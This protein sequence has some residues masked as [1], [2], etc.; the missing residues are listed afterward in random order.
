MRKEKLLIKDGEYLK[1]CHDPV[2]QSMFDHVTQRAEARGMMV[3]ENKTG[4]MCISAAQT[5][6]PGAVLYGK[7]GN[8]IESKEKMRILGFTLDTD[9]GCGSHVGKTILKIRR[10]SWAL[11]KLK[12]Y[13][14][15]PEE[16][17][18]VY[19]SYIRPIAEYVS[20]AWHSC[21][22]AEQA[23][24]LERQQT[25]ALRLIFGYG[26][27][28]RKLRQAANIELLSKRR[29]RACG[30]FAKKTQANPRFSSWFKEREFTRARRGSEK[31]RFH[32][33]TARTDR[34]RNSPLN[35]LTRRLNNN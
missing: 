12:R 1:T 23:A 8:V 20:A 11:Q 9:G 22:T 4:L 21:L 6:K 24:L 19:A 15:S 18:R 32:E 14:F 29:E 10:R 26:T 3:N 35:Y 27:S 33:P 16:L 25:H 28:A 31:N 2:S 34:Y 13:G 30:K 5:F 7:N 17:V